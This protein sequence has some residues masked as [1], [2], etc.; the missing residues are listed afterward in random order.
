MATLRQYRRHAI[1]VIF[2]IAAVV[3][4]TTDPLNM[5]LFALPLY[6]LYEAAILVAAMIGKRRSDVT[7]V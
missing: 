3:T 2:I 6:L 4:P 1:V 7:N 5:S